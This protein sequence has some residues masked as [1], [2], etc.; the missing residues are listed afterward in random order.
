MGL[1]SLWTIIDHPEDLM[2][3]IRLKMASARIEKEIPAEPHW[4]FCYGM[5]TKVSRSFALVIQQ[6]CTELRNAVRPPVS[7]SSPSSSY[8]EAQ[9]DLFLIRPFRGM[10]VYHF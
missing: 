1:G 9:S 3:L 2:P 10:L 8:V 7:I 6:L 5:L 4:A